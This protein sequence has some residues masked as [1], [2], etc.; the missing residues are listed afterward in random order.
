[1]PQQP[2]EFSMRTTLDSAN[3]KV[4]LTAIRDSDGKTV[5]IDY[6]FSAQHPTTTIAGALGVIYNDVD[7][8]LD[9]S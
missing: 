9:A 5:T 2:A 6:L 3:N 1:M 7:A 4:I 8:K